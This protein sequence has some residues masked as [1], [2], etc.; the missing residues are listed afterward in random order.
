M[1]AFTSWAKN[2]LQ[3]LNV[4]SSLFS[5]G[6]EAGDRRRMRSS[7]QLNTAG[8]NFI[9]DYNMANA[10]DPRTGRFAPGNP[11]GDAGSGFGGVY[12]N[13]SQGNPLSGF[14]ANE[15]YRAGQLAGSQQ[16]MNSGLKPFANVG[17]NTRGS[18][19]G[20]PPPMMQVNVDP[21][22]TF[23]YDP[24]AIQGT[25][26]AARR[27]H[28]P[29]PI[30]HL[31]RETRPV[32]EFFQNLF[33][34]GD[35]KIKGSYATGT[36]SV[37]ETGLY[38]LHKGEAVVPTALNPAAGTTPQPLI[39]TPVN[40]GMPQ[41]PNYRALNPGL[42]QNAQNSILQRGQDT[43]N[44]DFQAQMRNIR[45]TAGAAGRTVG[46]GMNRMLFDA[47]LARNRNISDMTRDVGLAAAERQFGDTLAANQFDLARY[48]SE[49]G[50]GLQQ[51]GLAQEGQLRRE[52]M[53]L[54][55]DRL[56]LDRQLGMEG[57]QVAR[58]GQQNDY[59]LG[60]QR[61]G[62][63]RYATDVGRQLEMGR[64]GLQRE[65]GR[66]E[67]FNTRRGQDINRQLTT[68]GQ[69]YDR[70]VST[71][72]QD[73]DRA[74]AERGQNFNRDLTQ[75]SNETNRMLGGRELDIR[76]YDTR[77]RLGLDNRRLDFDT[78][79]FLDELGLRG[80]GMQQDWARWNT[81]RNDRLSEG[82]S[83]AT[84][85]SEAYRQQMQEYIMTFLSQMA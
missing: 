39:S 80:L 67:L 79:A 36:T 73:F 16:M 6:S 56:A 50:L 23:R 21:A 52:E 4:L 71:R 81:E 51:A 42:D 26:Q 61:L 8:N 35:K 54:G 83:R 85:D 64:M 15:A 45:N 33:R 57:F 3:V 38:E 12:G 22:G 34:G 74:V 19:G 72:G 17:A 25:D 63:D 20:A 59:N 30:P 41:T 78:N 76:D 14:Q 68:R 84:A 66:E 55:R 69:D 62:H 37:P 7:R 2:P 82:G 58:A 53:G 18:S 49:G 70:Y 60:L 65:L 28:A 1:S 10:Y 11:F 5:F 31:E 43:I 44:R 46:G 13:D 40:G 9:N 29:Q 48:Q 75:Y 77:G 47:D 24:G 27:E 32:I